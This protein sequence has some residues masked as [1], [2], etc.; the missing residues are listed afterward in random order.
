MELDNNISRELSGVGIPMTIEGPC[1]PWCFTHYRKTR[2][3]H[4]TYI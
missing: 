4:F 1:M 2:T 3:T